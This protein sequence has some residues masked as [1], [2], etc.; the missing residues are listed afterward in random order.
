MPP[1]SI[2]GNLIMWGCHVP[3]PLNMWEPH[4]VRVPCAPRNM[5]E[6]HL[7][8][9]PCAPLNMWEPHL[10]RVPLAPLNM[11]EPHFVGV[12]CAPPPQYVGTSPCDGAMCP[13][14]ICGNLTL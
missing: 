8:R 6:P 4:L 12:P 10:V 11:W 7:V 9:V 13:L 14:S 1:S 2:C 5:W 3:L